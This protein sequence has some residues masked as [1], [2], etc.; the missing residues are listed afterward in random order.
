M[1]SRPMHLTM[2]T[3]IF[4]YRWYNPDNNRSVAPVP[5]H[6]FLEQP[7]PN[8]NHLPR[9]WVPHPGLSLRSISRAGEENR[10]I[11]FAHSSRSSEW[12]TLRQML[13][14]KGH[15]NPVQPPRWGTN[16]S[17]PPFTSDHKP[18]RYGHTNSPMTKYATIATRVSL[19]TDISLFSLSL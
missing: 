12:S 11:T 7:M 13:P 15:Y 18:K 1:Q 6:K 8:L 4:F 2:V 19:I 9:P 14:F 16:T 17:S 5:S 10:K 3:N